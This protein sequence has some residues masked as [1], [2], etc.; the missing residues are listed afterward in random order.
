MVS[1][2]A[3]YSRK[4]RPDETDEVLRRQLQYLIN[5][6][7]ENSW[8][9]EVF[10]EV[11]SSQSI[12]RPELNRLLEKVKN[13]EFDAIVTTD[14]D[15]LSRT[16]G[17]F[18]SIKEILIDYGVKVITSSKVYD[19][20]TQEDDLMSDMQ[21]VIS[22][23]EYLN[24][25]RRLIRGKRQSAKE[26]NWVGGKVPVGYS[27]DRKTKKLIPDENAYMIK[28]IYQLYIQG[29]SSTEIERQL[30]LEG[31]T[32][33]LGAAWSKSRISSVLSNPTYKGI[34]VYGKTKINKTNKSH[35][36]ARQIKTD[37]S[38][39][40]IIENAHTAIISIEDWELVAQIR[41][42]R[43]TKPPAVR[44]GKLPFSGLIKCGL[45]GHTHSFQRRKGKEL[46][47]T[48]CQTRV[49]DENGNYKVCKNSG[50]RL[51]QFERLFYFSFSEYINQLEKYTDQI[52]NSA[53]ASAKNID[54]EVT[55]IR[56]AIKRIENSIKKVQQ[57][58]IAGVFTEEEAKLEV[59]SLKHTKQ[60]AME[61]MEKLKDKSI[62]NQ[63]DELQ[64]NMEKLKSILSGTSNLEPREI[65][66]L[67][68]RYIDFIKYTRLDGEMDIKI[69][70]K[71]SIGS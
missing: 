5:M 13:F 70:F 33:P 44:I 69:Y 53:K 50:V 39:Q 48:S 67:F 54:D 17:G 30:T 45:C 34:A 71:G 6:C 52:R 15:R 10:Q 9:Y 60:K 18:A 16:T 37:T 41:E 49:Y 57:G 22:K 4:S 20:S 63:L 3:I 32:T 58:F 2:V 43:L 47:I 11:G 65:N 24:I 27:Y 40:I 42:E 1:K 14:Q 8:T 38:E 55:N 46:R 12:D 68:S 59:E 25:R 21:S 7:E 66:N 28:K 56:S 35:G 26:G 23:Q 61:R 64:A 36:A 31:I 51:E 29:L 19:Y 62:D